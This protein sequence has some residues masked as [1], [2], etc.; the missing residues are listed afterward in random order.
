MPEYHIRISLRFNRHF[1]VPCKSSISV[2]WLSI[3]CQFSGL[4]GTIQLFVFCIQSFGYLHFPARKIVLNF[5]SYC[6]RQTRTSL[7]CNDS[8]THKDNSCSGH[9]DKLV[10]E[11][12]PQGTHCQLTQQMFKLMLMFCRWDVPVVFSEK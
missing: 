8:A 6:T 3:P 7:F 10:A 4:Q 11:Q 9:P 1:T 12:R 5:W 2:K